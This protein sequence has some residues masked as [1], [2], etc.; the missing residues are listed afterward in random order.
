MRLF[1]LAAVAAASSAPARGGFV[2]GEAR[3]RMPIVWPESVSTPNQVRAALDA[4]DREL[5]RA[6][7]ERLVA[8]NARNA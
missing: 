6:L 4:H 2:M 3:A 1:K 7:G 8:W 5:Q